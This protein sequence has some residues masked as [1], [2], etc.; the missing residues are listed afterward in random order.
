MKDCWTSG[1][2][3]DLKT[4]LFGFLPLG[5]H[6]ITFE[7]IDHEG[8]LIQTRE[9][10]PL[11]NTWDHQITLSAHGEEETLYTD[12]VIIKAGGLTLPV[13]LFAKVLFF[14]RH[15][16]WHQYLRILDKVE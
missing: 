12:D 4:R 2:S 5:I 16:K 13:W 15:R 3:I 11:V 14:H 6:T 8:M 1:D 7:K 9:H 10:E